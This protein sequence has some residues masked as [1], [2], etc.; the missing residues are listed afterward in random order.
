L[1]ANAASPA[2]FRSLGPERVTPVP[3]A[4]LGTTA[5]A[6]MQMLFDAVN[7]AGSNS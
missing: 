7:A 6:G 2:V 1:P 5:C 4:R 3:G